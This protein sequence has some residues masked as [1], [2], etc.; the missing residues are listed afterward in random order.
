MADGHCLDYGDL[1][2][3]WDWVFVFEPLIALSFNDGQC[4]VDVGIAFTLTL[5]LSH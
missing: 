3:E 1:R 2:I 4:I 5:A